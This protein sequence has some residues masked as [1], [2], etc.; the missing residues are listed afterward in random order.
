MKT[1]KVVDIVYHE[2]EHNEVFAGTYDEC[3]NFIS[4]QGFGY[5]IVPMTVEEIENYPDNLTTDDN[6]LK[7]RDNFEK[8][9]G[10]HW[11]NSQG[12]PELDY[13][14]WLEKLVIG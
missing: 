3:F 13:V 14:L 10:E 6:V 11:L 12:E 8:E 9:M 4:E 7:L 2:D 1:H 5:K